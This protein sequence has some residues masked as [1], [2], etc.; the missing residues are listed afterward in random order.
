MEPFDF[1]DDIVC[2]GHAAE[3]GG[4]LAR[5]GA[6]ARIRHVAP[7]AS[8]GDP[9]I[10]RALCQRRLAQE[11]ADRGHRSVLVL[12][13]AALVHVTARE[14]LAAALVELARQRWGVLYLGAH[15]GTDCL[16]PAA[17]CRWLARAVGPMGGGGYALHAGALPALLAM[18]P[19]GFA[20]MEDWVIQ[21]DGAEAALARL[22][23]AFAVTPGIAVL[24]PSLPF[25]PIEAQPGFAP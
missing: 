3:A 13:A 15:A 7:A 5:F 16:G 25:Q 19:G 17:G 2:L 4:T 22:P 6:P 23:D 24:P 1:F 14:V 21:H 20:A 10:G 12:E 18:L 8:P 11:A 9:R